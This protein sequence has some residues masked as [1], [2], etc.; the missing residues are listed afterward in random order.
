M[1]WT[2][3]VRRLREQIKSERKKIGN[4][5]AGATRRLA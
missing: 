3:D 1:S 4:W 2:A 5:T